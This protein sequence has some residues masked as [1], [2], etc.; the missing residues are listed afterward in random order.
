MAKRKKKRATNKAGRPTKYKE[1]YCRQIIEYFDIE[2]TREVDVV[3]TFK[4]GTTRESTEERPNHLPF[5][6]NFAYSIGSNPQRLL[7]WCKKFPKFQEAYTRA[8]ALQKQHLVVCG[9]L[10]LFNS[11]FAVFTAKNITEWR[12]KQEL[13]HSG[14]D[15]QPIPVQ[16][17]DYRKADG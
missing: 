5:F 17:V 14:K 16:I 3:T 11:K 9:L 6:A 10:G 13:E 7:E 2:P 4:N 1:E 15:G 12:D 8:K